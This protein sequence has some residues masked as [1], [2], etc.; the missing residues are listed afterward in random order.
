M[1]LRTGLILAILALSAGYLAVMGYHSLALYR[2]AQRLRTGG[3]GGG[4]AQVTGLAGE[5]S[6][7]MRALRW[8]IAPFFPIFDILKWVPGVGHYAGQVE[9]LV[10]YG[11]YLSRAGED[12]VQ[13]L[14]P[15]ME[16]KTSSQSD[17]INRLVIETLAENHFQIQAANQALADAAQVR[18]QLDLSWLPGSLGAELR[19]FDR[20]FPLLQGGLGLLAQLPQLAGSDKPQTYLLVVQN[21]DE[22]RATGGFIAAFGLLQVDNGLITRFEFQDSYAVD[23]FAAGYPKPPAPLATYMLAGYWVPRDANW[24]PDYP[25]AARQIQALYSA[26]TGMQVDGVIA[27]DQEALVSV[28]RVLGPV[29]VGAL[30]E[31]VDADNVI[32]WMGRAWAPEPETGVTDEWWSQRKEFIGQLGTAIKDRLFSLREPDALAE[33]GYTTLQMIQAGHMLLYFNAPEAQT[34]LVQA[35]LDASVR[36]GPG[37]FLMLV[38]S[39][40][41]FNKADA[42]VERRLDYRVNLADLEHPQAVLRASYR[43]RAQPGAACKQ[44]AV[45][46]LTYEG[47]Q[48]RC[49]WNFWRVLAMGDSRLMAGQVAAI[50]AEQ[51]L[52]QKPY[53]GQIGQFPAEGGATE[54]SGMMVLPAGDHREVLIQWQLPSR[55]VHKTGG[56]YVYLLRI[57]KQPGLED[58]PVKLSLTIPGGSTLQPNKGWV[59]SVGAD[60]WEW[61]GV[62]AERTQFRLEF[63]AP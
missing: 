22:L 50:P 32:L 27:L 61:S 9:P 20:R 25:T 58:L 26:S 62:L 33:V 14:T 30:N 57:Q 55:V 44:E 24:S 4:A 6:A 54:F 12:V 46:N 45:Y 42:L 15:L 47:L 19:D 59:Q 7:H 17:P 16:E 28:L 31:S 48:Q 3:M 53:D 34:A 63:S 1:Q 35:G 36:P 11:Y 2:A 39:N 41:G 29:N 8:G 60:T 21:N 18:A 56:E 38:D 43:S 40:V 52:A 51:L 13:A 37:D 23:N 5:M 49:Y 10:L